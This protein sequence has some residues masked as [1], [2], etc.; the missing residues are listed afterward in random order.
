VTIHPL[1]I[2][3]ART[4]PDGPRAALPAALDETASDEAASDEVLI[5]RIAAGDKRAMQALYRRHHVRLYRFVL[6][7][8]R[9]RQL[10]EDL[11]SEAFL[12]VWRGASTF[13]ARSAA[14]TWLMAIA[15]FKALSSL[16]RRGDAQLE[17]ETAAA[18]ADRADDP[19][20]TIRKKQQGEILRDCLTRLSP[21]HRETIDLVY[22][23]GMG[24][25]EVAAIV[26]IPESTVKTRMFHARKQLSVLLRAAGVDRSWP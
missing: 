17:D 9:D 11:V 13:A 21:D 26:G 25:S 1:R 7:F 4:L 2:N 8:V 23:Q 3:V 5:V 15:R 22:Y 20:V 16:R 10:A 18:T 19:E 6:R 12:D 14:S 24:I